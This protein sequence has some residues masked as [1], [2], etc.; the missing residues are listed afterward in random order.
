MNMTKRIFLAIGILAI[1]LIVFFF[2]LTAVFLIYILFVNPPWFR[3][4]LDNLDPPENLT[5]GS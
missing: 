5:K 1:D 2:P 3:E 4:F